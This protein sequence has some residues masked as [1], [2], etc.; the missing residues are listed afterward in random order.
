MH[1]N[2]MN[3]S[4]ILCVNKTKTGHSF[5]LKVL[6]SVFILITADQMIGRFILT[7]TNL[8]FIYI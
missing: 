5:I 7:N 6:R 4:W 2:I 1:L 3:K 8:M